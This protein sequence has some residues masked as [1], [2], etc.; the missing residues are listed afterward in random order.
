MKPS[1]VQDAVI[2]ALEAW[3]T[4][5]AFVP[6]ILDDSQTNWERDVLEALDARG[7]CIVV[8]NVV[9]TNA[10]IA[11]PGKQ[12]VVKCTAWLEIYET[13][14]V[15]H[16]PEGVALIEAVVEALIQNKLVTGFTSHAPRTEKGGTVT[17][18]LFEVTATI[19]VP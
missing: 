5:S 9:S 7:V 13:R 4:V 14:Q 3:P 10:E 11:F 6:I 2:S 8:G 15:A 1:E 19:G 17:E 16:S 12:A 18:C